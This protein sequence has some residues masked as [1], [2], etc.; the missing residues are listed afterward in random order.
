MSFWVS[1]STPLSFAFAW[2]A[3]NLAFDFC[4]TVV[5]GASVFTL[6]ERVGPGHG[7]GL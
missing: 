5:V 2:A 7:S 1:L 3:L 6:V 4:S